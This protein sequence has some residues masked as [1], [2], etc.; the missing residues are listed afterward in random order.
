[1]VEDYIQNV[2]HSGQLDSLF[3]KF[4]TEEF[5]SSKEKVVR[6]KNNWKYLFDVIMKCSNYQQLIEDNKVGEGN[7]DL[8]QRYKTTRE[9]DTKSKKTLEFSSS[10][11]QPVDYVQRPLEDIYI[12][13]A[14]NRKKRLIYQEHLKHLYQTTK[15]SRFN[16]RSFDIDGNKKNV[17]KE[18][19]ILARNIQTVRN[20]SERVRIVNSTIAEPQFSK[21]FLRHKLGNGNSK[22]VLIQKAA[23]IAQE[24]DSR[25][26][27]SQR[28]KVQLTHVLNPD[29]FKRTL[30]HKNLVNANVI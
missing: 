27:F 9:S 29:K 2:N 21:Q 14:Y 24:T 12:D 10:N 16:L 28:P 4:K 3:S 5:D 30:T 22:T 8:M 6:P 23:A 25:F 13:Y 7:N 19:D 11:A 18:K 26:Q 20:G 17:K 1:M 15:N